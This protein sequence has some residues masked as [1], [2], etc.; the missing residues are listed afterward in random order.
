MELRHCHCWHSGFRGRFRN[1][2]E[3]LPKWR[4]IPVMRGSR[5]NGLL[6]SKQHPPL[7]GP[8]FRGG[9]ASSRSPSLAAHWVFKARSS[10]AGL[11]LQIR[12]ESKLD[13][14]A[15]CPETG[16]ACIQLPCIHPIY[17]GWLTFLRHHSRIQLGHI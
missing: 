9:D 15:V 16:I 4:K 6:F 8:I 7:G 11:R 12:I 14:L 10:P 17:M 2:P 3:L 1:C 5:L 13:K